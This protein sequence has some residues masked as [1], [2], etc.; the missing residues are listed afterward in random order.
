MRNIRAITVPATRNGNTTRDFVSAAK[1]ASQLAVF[2]RTH[3]PQSLSIISFLRIV[4]RVYV[5]FEKR[6]RLHPLDS[7][8]CRLLVISFE[9]KEI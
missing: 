7:L 3:A 5:I 6:Y 4:E 1:K 2:V 9:I 8:V